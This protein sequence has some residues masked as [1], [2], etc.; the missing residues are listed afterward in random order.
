MAFLN[1]GPYAVSSSLLHDIAFSTSIEASLAS[2]CHTRPNVLRALTLQVS[3][4][5]S[6]AAMMKTSLYDDTKTNNLKTIGKAALPLTIDPR[7][8]PRVPKIV[9]ATPLQLR[10]VLIG[11]GSLGSLIA[12]HL[13]Q[14]GI[15]HPTS[16]S[17]VTRQPELLN[18]FA[19]K[20]VRCFPQDETAV[21]AEADVIV[22][23]C[24]P[25]QL[26]M[27]SKRLHGKIPQGCVI[28]SVL[29]GISAE[30]LRSE[31]GSPLC[32]V[33]TVDVAALAFVTSKAVDA[34]QSEARE[35]RMRSIQ[36]TDAPSFLRGG[37]SHHAAASKTTSYEPEPPST[38]EADVAR[39]SFPSDEDGNVFCD[40]AVDLLGNVV[41]TNTLALITKRRG[42]GCSPT[43]QL[44]TVWSMLLAQ[45][46]IRNEVIETLKRLL[47]LR[48]AKA[49]P[50]D[51]RMAQVD[52]HIRQSYR[53]GVLGLA[54][55]VD[56]ATAPWWSPT[57]LLEFLNSPVSIGELIENVALQYQN[58]VSNK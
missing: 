23:A 30:K 58:L 47:A 8:S 48:D 7:V 19:S 35:R 22:C 28:V 42:D 15:L 26:E 40:Q 57:Y 54:S 44:L 10:V 16:L 4:F 11:C 25:G 45:G 27:V 13:L 53:T 9:T 32:L 24:Q 56:A 21:V 29:C 55:K 5:V 41:W 52:E 18:Q 33:A 39:L 2:V 14:R 17:I 6:I 20:G 43:S 51:P 1:G 49:E 38:L 37:V 31:F 46:P 3:Y 50:D 36:E 34:V 12:T